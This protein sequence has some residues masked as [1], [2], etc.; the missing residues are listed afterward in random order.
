MKDIDEKELVRKIIEGNSDLFKQILIQNSKLVKLIVNRMIMNESLRTDIVQDIFIKVFVGLKKFRFESKLSSWIA[1][2]AVNTCKKKW[3]TLKVKI[4][5]IEDFADILIPPS[6]EL[7]YGFHSKS[8]LNEIIEKAILQLNPS[9]RLIFSLFH[10]QDM[11]IDQINQITSI[12][13]G[14]IK[15]HLFRSRLYLKKILKIY[16][17]NEKNV[18]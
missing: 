14:T 4:D 5:P 15:S 6:Q 7:G 8:E 18:V 16:C 10:Q 1:A 17:D 3:Q 12:P 13:V 2:I 11:T 9:A